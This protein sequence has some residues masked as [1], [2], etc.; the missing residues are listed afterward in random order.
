M[1][2]KS[3]LLTFNN[4]VQMP[5]L[6]LG[7]FQT[8]PEETAHAV[9]QAIADGYRLIDTAAAYHNER[10]V[11]EGLRR[12]GIDRKEVFVTTKL[13]VG[14]FGYESGL[15]AFDRSLGRLAMDYVDLY[16]LHW[17]APSDF[18]QTIAAY[19]AAEK[20]LAEGRARA[21]GISNFNP[22]HLET[23]LAQSDVVP[24]LNQVELH[25]FFVQLEVRAAD[26]RRGVITQSWSPLGGA[27]LYHATDPSTKG[28]LQ[29]PT[30]L[31]LAA[32]YGKTPAQVVLR[33]HIQL[34]LSAIPKSVHAERIAENID[35]FD[36][37]LTAE[38][39]AAI[40]ALDTGMR[41]GGD[42]TK[43]AADTYPTTTDD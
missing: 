37:E 22:D 27:V 30:V 19:H 23:L 34:G 16:L 8:P 26:A 41:S 33:W 17:P 13:W 21:I 10:Q 28:P 20:I 42:P 3:P 38:E 11:G 25:P 12:S 15:R 40:E 9:E 18:D 43:V 32:K 35:I 4:G 39:L 5:A 31:G 24:A 2:G 29:H 14:D 36:F 1:T 7:V 6:G